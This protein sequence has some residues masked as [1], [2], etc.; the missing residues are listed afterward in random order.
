MIKPKHYSILEVFNFSDISLCFNFYSTK[1]SNF[2]VSD[3]T[4]ITS[5]NIILTNETNFLPTYSNAILLKEYDA[6]KSRYQF[7]IAPQNYHSI[8][9]LIDGVA[10]WLSE[11]AETAHDTILKVSLSFN[12][13]YLETLASISGMNPTKLV[14][15]FDENFVY[16]RFPEQKHSPY[17]LSIKSLAPI[18]TYINEKEISQNVDYLIT[19]PSAEYYGIDFSNYTKGI[20]ECNYIG[21]KEYPKKIKQIKEII[22]YFVLKSYQ[23]LNEQYYTVFEID[24]LKRICEDF[25]KMQMAYLD[26]E[27]FLK[28]FKDLKVYLDLKTSDQL[29]KSYWPMLRKPL[30]EMIMNGKLRQGQFNYDTET[31]RYQL[32]KGYIGGTLLK[33]LD[34]IKCEITG[35]LENCNLVDCNLVNSRAYDSKFVQ[36]NKIINSYLERASINN[37]NS[38][39]NSYIVNNEEVVNCDIKESVIKFAT[40]GKNM[41]LDENSTMI[42]RKQLLPEKTD[43]LEVPKHIRDYS[44]IKAMHKGE[45]KG[46]QNAYDRNKYLKRDKNNEK[47][48]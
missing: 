43:A 19:L 1:E 13:R 20:L 2:I 36:G 25:G 23:S 8:L 11:S 10:G 32:R 33:N 28:E 14:L 4:N 35:V 34:L 3:L 18:T 26:P 44:W 30:F 29:L 48:S 47:I 37:N 7:T 41:I 22:E 17:A 45:D 27:V 6:K 24:E 9:P 16:E 21:G 42:V 12:H 38:V 46:F 31:G 15:K 5:K 39:I 40:P